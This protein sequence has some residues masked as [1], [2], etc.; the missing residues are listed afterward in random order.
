MP[1]SEEGRGIGLGDIRRIPNFC[2]A[3]HT[4]LPAEQPMRAEHKAQPISGPGFA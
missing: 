3:F 1:S 4:R 2:S